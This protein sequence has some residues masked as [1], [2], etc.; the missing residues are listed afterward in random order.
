[1]LKNE[2]IKGIIGVVGCVNPRNNAEEW[3]NVFKKLSKD[4][5]IFTTGCMAFEF[6]KHNLLDG[7]RFFHLGSCV[8]NSRIA[9]IFKRI[10]EYL[11]KQINELPFLISAP[12]PIA[13]KSMA[14]ALFFA[15]LGCS[16]H[17]GYP[18]LLSSD[19]DVASFLK[20][21]LFQIFKTNIFFEAHPEH[22][23]NEI[24]T[25]FHNPA[26]WI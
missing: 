14:I 4:Y 8:N 5:I 2:E 1:M 24:N 22:F 6:G 20:N 23:Y 25:G 12:M 18:Y 19:I 17:S 21:T 15:S 16:I 7:E 3:V 11:G 10:S 26:T 9:E 13:E